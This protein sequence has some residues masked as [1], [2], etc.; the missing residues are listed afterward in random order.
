MQ[1]RTI[2]I[3]GLPVYSSSVE[4]R[5]ADSSN[6]TNLKSTT[7]AGWM[8]NRSTTGV[9]VNENN[10]LTLS[11][12]YGGVKRIAES[13]ALLSGSAYLKDDN[14]RKPAPDH[15][16][17]KLIFNK[18]NH[19]HTPFIFRLTAVYQVI[20]KGNSYWL[21]IRD[22]R[23][24]P[25]ELRYL[26]PSD[27]EPFEDNHRIYYRVKGYDLPLSSDD[28]LH[29]KGMG[30]DGVK[31]VSV[32]THARESLGISLSGQTFAGKTFST[33]GSKRVAL[34]TPQKLDEPAKEAMRKEWE[35]LYG[36]YQNAHRLA[37]LDAGLGVKDIGVSPED[38]QLLESRKFGIDDIA[39]FLS[40]P[41]HMLA[42]TDSSS[43][44]NEE[45]QG[46]EYIKYTIGAWIK[47]FEEEI[48]NK[49]VFEKERGKIYCK[50]N[51]N[52][53]ARGDMTARSNYYTKMID[54]GVMCSNEVRALEEMN[55]RD[56]GDTY[57]T[58][59][60]MNT[61]EQLELDIEEMKQQLENLKAQ[62]DG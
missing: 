28:I 30:A 29:F 55:P 17:T 22:E 26:K 35:N 27:V 2:K 41:R 33:G 13:I 51:V 45:H 6:V 49:L 19:L 62:N 40:L 21:I 52:S 48:N 39:R 56:G 4:S 25:I 50:F 47:N 20:N 38:A 59:L 43:Y 11:A 16:I 42:N 14:S 31:G 18:P 53:F 3:L 34:E 60:N 44:K 54:R 32:L 36:G 24:Q 1:K 61:Q 58:P 57:L 23:M 10:A 9:S 15:P 5:A 12:Y 46:G 37:I 7:L 8:G